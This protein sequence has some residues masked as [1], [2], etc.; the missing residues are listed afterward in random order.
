MRRSLCFFLLWLLPNEKSLKFLC[1]LC[2]H[3]IQKLFVEQFFFSDSIALIEPVVLPNKTVL[4][5][6]GLRDCP[7]NHFC[8]I[9]SIK[10]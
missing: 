1:C 5:F 6:F 8:D 4:S 9:P 2:S 7:V 10:N 3:I